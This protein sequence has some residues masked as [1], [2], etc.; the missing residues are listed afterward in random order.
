MNK[1]RFCIYIIMPA[2]FIS[3]NPTKTIV[4]QTAKGK[5]LRVVGYLPGSYNWADA[6]NSI[7]LTMITD[8]NLAFINPDT[9]G[10]FPANDAY[11]QVIQ[12]AHNNYVR[13]FLSIGGGAPPAHLAGLLKNDNRANL[14]AG[15]V[16][17]AETYD[18]DG[19]DVDL[20]NALINADYAPFVSQLS[21]ALRSKNK[22][23]TAALASWN[24]NLIGDTTLQ[25]Y[26]F[27]NIMSYDKTGPW[28]LNKPGQH[29]PFTMARDDFNYF[30]QTRKIAAEKLFIGLPFY[31]YGFGNGA[32]QSMK[33]K[34]IIATYPGSENT[35]SV[36][37]AGGG[38]IYYNGIPTIKQKVSFAINNK[39]GGIMIWQLMGDS[40]DSKSLLKIID[41]TKKQ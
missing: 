9:S 24:S 32:P 28:N 16:K 22:L 25:L 34:D 5:G 27:I 39:A 13:V 2:L 30:N 14:I 41:D 37:V 29:S 26:D 8:L 3:C 18:F 4:S 38:T 1:L 36:T 21:A 19:V 15:L 10:N 23:M 20:E 31:G 7:D 6:I 11:P 40:K 12:K 35:D 33:Y 17:F